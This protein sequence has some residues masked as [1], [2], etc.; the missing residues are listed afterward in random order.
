[1]KPLR[2]LLAISLALNLIAL[3]YLGY[4]FRN[5][6]FTAVPRAN[7]FHRLD[8]V[9]MKMP[10]RDREIIFLG[11][12]LTRNFLV[13]ELFP[14]VTTVNRGINGDDTFGVLGRINEITASQPQKI[15]IEVG[16]NDLS[17]SVP[18]DTIVM[19]YNMIIKRIKSQSPA[20]QI[21]IQS[22]LPT[23]RVIELQYIETINKRLQEISN[24]ENTTYIDLYSHFI[25]GTELNTKYDCGD[26]VHL[27]G[28][29]YLLWR[30]LVKDFVYTEAI[31]VR[32]TK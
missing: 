25:R 6:L 17:R 14:G 16:I 9:F 10:N 30:D 8:D 7:Y 21:Y 19:N 24:T 13:D 27:S 32:H 15:F 11:N 2:L 5:K 22:L 20:T 4:S 1:M 31:E 12:S 23:R 26:G 3:V 18:V 29:G 28:D